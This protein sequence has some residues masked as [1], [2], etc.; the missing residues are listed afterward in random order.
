M[1]STQTIGTR[2]AASVLA[3]GAFALAGLQAQAQSAATSRSATTN[4][5]TN[6]RSSG[7]VSSARVGANGVTSVSSSGS[8]NSNNSGNVYTG[9]ALSYFGYPDFSGFGSYLGQSSFSGFNGGTL[10]GG[11]ITFIGSD[12]Y[13]GF[14]T[15]GPSGTYSF[16]QTIGYNPIADPASP[17]YNPNANNVNSA[18]SRSGSL[19]GGS[20]QDTQAK[21]LEPSLVQSLFVRRGRN[22]DVSIGWR[23][24]SRLI[25]SLTV[26][27]LNRY[28]LP[29]SQQTAEA[30]TEAYFPANKDTF[31]A[32]YYRVDVQY[33]DGAVAS[34]VASL[35]K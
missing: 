5:A 19:N 15:L 20:S 14:S 4:A 1:N 24:D 27:L 28:H 21:P 35:Q 23:G 11:N 12:T 32:Q 10:G 2:Y 7:G 22:F 29:I 30:G 17:A 26:T 25:S 13:G 6:I 31:S 33:A 16:G 9:S 8:A 34:L 3:I 18:R